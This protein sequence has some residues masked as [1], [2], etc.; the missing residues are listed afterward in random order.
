MRHV[1]VGL[2]KIPVTNFD[3][4]THYYREVLGLEEEFAV[5]AYG[6][7]QYKTGNVPLCLYTV[8]QGGGD[9]LPG[10]E[11]GLHLE[12]DNLKEV[13]AEIKSRGGLF[14]SDFVESDDG[15]LFFVVKDPDDN[16][17]KIVQ[18]LT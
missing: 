18:S 2:V 6:W 9:G 1:K 8:G 10:G 5:K 11:Q 3:K 4:S 12:V 17:F 16:R 14:A 13:Y 15:G 7:A